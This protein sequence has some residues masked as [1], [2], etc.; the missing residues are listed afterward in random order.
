MLVSLLLLLTFYI[1][2]TVV[3]LRWEDFFRSYTRPPKSV[4]PTNVHAF[5]NSML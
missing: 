4:R 2:K 3:W 5:L 1:A